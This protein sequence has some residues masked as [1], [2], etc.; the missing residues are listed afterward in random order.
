M[1]AAV[2]VFVLRVL[3]LVAFLAALF[4]GVRWAMGQHD[5]VVVGNVTG[6][7]QTA[8]RAAETSA[9]GE[10]QQAATQEL[11]TGVR[12]G[13]AISRASRV[14]SPPAAGQEQPMIGNDTLR[15]IVGQG[16]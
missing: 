6:A 11:Q 5:A 2:E 13:Q 8:A 15:N 7:T 1:L 9:A 16:R 12:A 3:M 10:Q 14:V 4:F